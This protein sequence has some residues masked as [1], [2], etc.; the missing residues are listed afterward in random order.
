[1]KIKLKITKIPAGL[2]GG[3]SG[4]LK[5]LEISCLNLMTRV[6]VYLKKFWEHKALESDMGGM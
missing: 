3:F 2:L 1:M 5:P 4:N 6:K